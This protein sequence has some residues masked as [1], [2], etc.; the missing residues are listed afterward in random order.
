MRRQYASQLSARGHAEQAAA[1]LLAAQ[2][3]SAGAGALLAR[4]TRGA[5]HAA[6][7]LCCEMSAAV[8]AGFLQL[9]AEEGAA[10]EAVIEAAA[11]QL[12]AVVLPGEPESLRL[13]EQCVMASEPAA[14]FAAPAP[15]GKL[16]T[17]GEA[18]GADEQSADATLMVE[19]VLVAEH[20]AGRLAVEEECRPVA[21]MTAGPEGHGSRGSGPRL[22]YTPSE[23]IELREGAGGPPPALPPDLLLLT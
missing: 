20:A 21:A 1:Q 22:R 5:A 4:G 3:W 23:L 7:R 18:D 10:L 8:A 17:A 16:G 12:A 19:H 14:G 6:A 9:S 13:L 2:S 15:P 11:A